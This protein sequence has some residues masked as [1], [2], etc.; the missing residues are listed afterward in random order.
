[1]T[2][3][4]F[5]SITTHIKKQLILTNSEEMINATESTAVLYVHGKGGSAKEAEHWF[6][7]DEQMEFLD[8]WI[9]SFALS[10]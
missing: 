9:D 5:K 2:P 6:H 10:L 7:T 4:V 3:E 1:M 8:R